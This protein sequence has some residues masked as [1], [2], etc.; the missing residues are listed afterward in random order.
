MSGAVKLEGPARAAALAELIDL[1]WALSE[2]QD[3]V[4]KAWK[5]KTF[6]EAWG[7][8]SRVALRAEKL[9]HHPDWRNVYATVEV[10]LTTHSCGGL[11]ELDLQLARAMELYAGGAE[12]V[13]KGG[14]CGCA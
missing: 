12:A 11:S 10:V 14:D 1:G 13:A 7:F 8:M 2:G 3:A 9:N 5:F 6:S 4:E